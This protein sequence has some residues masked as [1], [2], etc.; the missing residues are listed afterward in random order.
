MNS[1]VPKTG[2]QTES[3]PSGKPGDR[4]KVT[5]QL[6]LADFFFVR[7]RPVCA[8]FPL[9]LS[10]V[11]VSLSIRTSGIASLDDAGRSQF[12]LS[13]GS[14]DLGSIHGGFGV[15]I[16]GTVAPSGFLGPI[17]PHRVILQARGY[18]DTVNGSTLTFTEDNT[19]DDSDPSVTDTDPQ[20]GG[21]GGKI[22]DLDE[23]SCFNSGTAPDGTIC[24]E[25]VN[26]RE[27][28]TLGGVQVSN[29]LFWFARMSNKK[30]SGADQKLSDITGDNNGGQGSTAITWNL[31]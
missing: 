17:V 5:H 6:V 24:R 30:V 14:A 10:V 19:A 1:Q 21:S 27:Y 9:N 7:K 3:N 29:D 28:A 16:V 2:G 26:F 18:R 22:Y 23:P 13:T 15:E 31:Q 25:R 20:S 12:A 8:R 4:R 11:N